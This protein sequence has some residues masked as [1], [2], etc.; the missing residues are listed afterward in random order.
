MQKFYV[1]LHIWPDVKQG[2]MFQVLDR[3]LPD[4][5]QAGLNRRQGPINAP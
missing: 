3:A 5:S 2:I 1:G 4:E